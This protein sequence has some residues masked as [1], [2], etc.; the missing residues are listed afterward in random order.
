MT[1]KHG[2]TSRL[3]FSA[4]LAALLGVAACGGGSSSGSGSGSSAADTT[5]PTVSSTSPADGDSGT[6]RNG[7]IAAT[8]SEAMNASTVDVTTFTLEQGT[9]PVPGTVV[10]T[11]AGTT[12]IFSPTATLA[13]GTN[14]TGTITT[15][16]KDPSDNALA[17]NFIWS[18]TTG[19][20]SD[21]TAP[22][23]SLKSPLASATLVFLNS[24]VSATFDKAMDSSTLT[25]ST[26]TLTGPGAVGVSGSIGYDVTNRTATLRPASNLAANTAYDA[27]VT[28]GAKDLAGNALGSNVT[29]RFT[30][31][32]AGSQSPGTVALASAGNFAVL[33]FNTVTNV[34]NVGTQI[35][36]DVGISPG[37][38]LVGFPP[39]IVNGSK[40]VGDNVAKQAEADLLAAYNDAA[41][42]LGALVLPQDL[43]G[44]TF[45]PGV[46]KNS[47]SVQISTGNLT[48]DAKG[49]GN[50]VFIFQMGSTLTTSSATH[51]ILAGG[52]RATNVFWAVGTSA[53]LGTN[54]SF[55]GNILAASA[56]TLTTGAALE[57]RALAKN[58]AVAL[59]TNRI[60]VPAQ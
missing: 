31:G 20:T 35:I 6:A 45:A 13:A 56:V 21:T 32:A 43:A 26:F 34:N 10:Y 54:S 53:T 18:F 12:A 60:T 22:N 7:K 14:Y 25:T 52:A 5:T 15:G 46:Y 58:A 17:A 8:F 16:A 57:G 2:F 55:K 42:R 49:D 33:A 41:G 51:V 30:T 44:L 23:V 1:G 24:S 29:W 36:G 4:P 47:T 9:T 3:L 38:A 27:T 11:D 28:M 50:A 19:A 48:L 37:T 40:H 59:D 39:G